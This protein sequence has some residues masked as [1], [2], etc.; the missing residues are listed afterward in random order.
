MR[1]ILAKLPRLMQGSMKRLLQQVFLAPS[2]EMAIKRGR[3]LIARFGDRYPAAIECLERDLEECVTYLRFPE[4]HR[5]RIRTTNR[6]ER[7]NGESRRRTK[8]IPRFPT[9]RSCLTLLYASL[10][11]ASK[12]WRGIPMTAK[13]VRQLQELRS[14][15]SANNGEAVA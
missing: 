10:L 2:Y 4:A 7:L 12:R 14:L 6:L 1:N 5:R 13:I 11:A 9:E 15:N 8:V 3:A